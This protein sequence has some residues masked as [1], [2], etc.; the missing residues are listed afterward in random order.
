L[1][2]FFEA[3][4]NWKAEYIARNFNV[5]YYYTSNLKELEEVLTQFYKPQKDNRPAILEIKTPNKRNASILKSY[6]KYLKD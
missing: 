3:K 2:E 4:H 6:F 1:E 5:P